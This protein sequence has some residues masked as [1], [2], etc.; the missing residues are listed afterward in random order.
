MEAGEEIERWT[1]M[2]KSKTRGERSKVRLT[3]SG[4][5]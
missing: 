5:R 2:D 3:I 4:E 1:K